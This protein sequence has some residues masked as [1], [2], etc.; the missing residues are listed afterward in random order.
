MSAKDRF[1]EVVVGNLPMI[2]RI[3]TAYESNG[4]LAEELAQDIACAVWLALPSF[5]GDAAPKT[6]VARIA[7]NRAV[8]HVRRTL[9]R[10][11]LAELSED[12]PAGE[13]TPEWQV[14]ARD[15]RERL[16]AAVRHLPLAQRQVALLTLEGF[17]APE[18]GA[19][20][21][22]SDNAVRVRLSRARAALLQTMGDMT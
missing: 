19:V 17:T 1:E 5:R 16:V 13:P 15:G 8:S 4:H 12:L 6:F 9:S 3:A 2:R 10:P 7:T 14:I 18:V 22:I 21:G 11:Q 20:L